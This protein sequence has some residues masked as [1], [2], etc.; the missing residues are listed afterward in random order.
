MI[1]IEDNGAAFTIPAEMIADAFKLDP[2]DV[3]AL[4]QSG[5][6]AVT[7]EVGTGEDA[8]RFRLTISD[9][10]A[11]L[12]LIIDSSGTIISHS[13]LDFG[14]QPLPPAARRAGAV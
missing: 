10:H 4:L 11:R 7:S 13:K 9:A 6:I 3:P 12:R 14:S 2:A 1:E 5:A 8:G